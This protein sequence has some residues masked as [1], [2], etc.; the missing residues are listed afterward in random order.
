MRTN[1]TIITTIFGTSAILLTVGGATFAAGPKSVPMKAVTMT[2]S[3]AAPAVSSTAVE[4]PKF[5]NFDPATYKGETGSIALPCAGDSMLLLRKFEDGKLGDYLQIDGKDKNL[6]VPVGAYKVRYC[7]V[8][9]SIKDGT[10][11]TISYSTISE[12]DQLIR[13][14]AGKLTTLPML[15]EAVKAVKSAKTATVTLPYE[16]RGSVWLGPSLGENSDS[17][18]LASSKTNKVTVP[19][20]GYAIFQYMNTVTDKD[21]GKWAFTSMLLPEQGTKPGDNI[22]MEISE[23]LTASITAKQDGDKL[24]LAMAL[25][26]ENGRICGIQRLDRKGDPPGFQ[27]LSA[28]GEVLMSGKFAYG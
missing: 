1:K 23:P 21:G 27:V 25:A 7:S 12:I 26:D 6:S 13:I 3:V 17:N 16:G 28:L 14:K 11:W 2:T 4:T 24:K 8:S 20:E 5:E 22:K 15:Q 18:V 10:T 9:I 19:V